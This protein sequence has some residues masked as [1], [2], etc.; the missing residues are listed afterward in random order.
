MNLAELNTGKFDSATQAKLAPFY[1]AYT[2]PYPPA[3][4]WRE[5][6]A[7]GFMPIEH[8]TCSLDDVMEGLDEQ[9]LEF[10]YR[11]DDDGNVISGATDRPDWQTRR[12]HQ[13]QRAHL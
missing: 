13:W 9:T 6:R 2:R 11:L 10:S 1:L 8:Q 5:L 4:T 7:E 3:V 12:I